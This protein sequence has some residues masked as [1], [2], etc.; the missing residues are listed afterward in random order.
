M[1]PGRVVHPF[2][3][4]AEGFDQPGV[5]RARDMHAVIDAGARGGAVGVVVQ[6]VAAHRGIAAVVEQDGKERQAGFAGH[7]KA[8]GNGIVQK[9]AVAHQGDHGLGRL[10]Q[11]DAQGQ[12]QPLAQP[13]VGLEVALGR[14]P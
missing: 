10:R 2:P 5:I 11:L 14:I 9:A 6:V 7:A 8:L 4:A 1:E 3:V 13:A 12:T